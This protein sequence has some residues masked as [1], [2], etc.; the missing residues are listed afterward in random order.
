MQ[1]AVP[2]YDQWERAP[3]PGRLRVGCPALVSVFLCLAALRCQARLNT[4]TRAKA[5]SGIGDGSC[6]WPAGSQAPL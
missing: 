2:Q 1:K 5:R 6:P 4:G 3:G